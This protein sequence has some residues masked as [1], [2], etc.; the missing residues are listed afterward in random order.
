MKKQL[1][2]LALFVFVSTGAFADNGA[3]ATAQPAQASASAPA[4]PAAQAAAPIVNPTLVTVPASVVVKDPVLVPPT[5]LQDL[6]ISAESLPTI[7]PI[8]V[9]VLQYLAILVTMLTALC[10][11]AIAILKALSGVASMAN[12]AG[13]AD[14]VSSFEDSKIMYWL[15]FAS[16]FNAQKPQPADSAGQQKAA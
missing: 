2:C 13:L 3:T 8:L 14:K 7:G 5:W 10:A 11:C 6:I 15:K 4:V 16:A 12:L 1:S 9:K